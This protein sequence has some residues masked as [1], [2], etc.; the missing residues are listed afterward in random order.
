M[1][2]PESTGILAFAKAGQAEA[3]LDC[4]TDQYHA[5]RMHSPVTDRS[6][7]DGTMQDIVAFGK[8]DYTWKGNEYII[9][10]TS[11]YQDYT[12][13]KNNYILVPTKEDLIS[14]GR[15]Q[16]TDELIAAASQWSVDLHDEVWV[17]DQ[18]Y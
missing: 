14:N 13:F 12:I 5:W 6:G 1:V 18:E 2:T 17:F 4:M 10:T 11:Y 7:K 8:Y 15:S 3:K 16:R 9:Y